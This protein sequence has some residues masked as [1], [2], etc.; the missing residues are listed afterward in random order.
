MLVLHSCLFALAI[1][2]SQSLASSMLVLSCLL[3]GEGIS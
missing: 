1:H 3:S 2:L